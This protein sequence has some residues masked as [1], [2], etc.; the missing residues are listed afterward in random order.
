MGAALSDDEPRLSCDTSHLETSHV[1][2][3]FWN[4]ALDGVMAMVNTVFT[5]MPSVSVA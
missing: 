3:H 5:D 1:P 4:A 2:V